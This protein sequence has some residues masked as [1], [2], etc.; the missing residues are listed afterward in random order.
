MVA[1]A[2]GTRNETKRARAK[3]QRF[4]DGCV[5]VRGFATDDERAAGG[6]SV[7]G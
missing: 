1:F 7:S 5:V 6:R 3:K 2:E 4:M